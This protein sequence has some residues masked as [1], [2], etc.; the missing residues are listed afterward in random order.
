MIK[1]RFQKYELHFKQAAGTS[2]G[3]LKTRTVWYLFLEENGVTGL[4]ECA[5]LPGLSIE[6]PEQV[7]VQLDKICADPKLF[8][9]NIDL[10]KDISSLKFALESALL[11]LKNGG[12]RDPFPSAFSHG[13]EGIP[14]N[15]LI[16]MNEIENM[17][18]QIEEKLAAGFRCIKLKIGAKDFEQELALL[19]AV[20]ERFS[21]DQIV[22]RVDAN[23]AF[24]KDSA[25]EKLKRL[26][27]LQLHSIEQP[28]PAGLWNEMAE[29]CKTTPLPI[30]LDEELIGINDRREKIQLLDTI[31][32]QFLV[33]KPSLHGGISGCDEWINLANER[34]IGWW[35][36]SY[37]ESNIG[38]NV[39]AQ[40]A[41]TKNTTMHQGL[42][43]GQLFTNNIES[44]LEIRGEE[45]WFN[46]AKSFEM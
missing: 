23:G 44:P 22:L 46:T 8:I 42:G 6:T 25:D 14:I 28:I 26:A 10:L 40:W 2:R 13:K 16:W 18:R 29:L 3:V 39:I 12:K 19:K 37:L 30:A 15:G 45:L 27:E 41:F 7:E 34:S 35:I 31:R 17:Q 4:G 32:P 36:T 24:D 9:N 38:L 21:S 33:L 43:T 11:D 1:A 5:P 20:R